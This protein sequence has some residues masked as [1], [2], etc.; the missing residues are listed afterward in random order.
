MA[1]L[2]HKQ[3][4]QDFHDWFSQWNTYACTTN[5]TQ[6]QK[7]HN[8]KYKKHDKHNQ[9]GKVSQTNHH[10]HHH[11]HH[12]IHSNKENSN[13]AIKTIPK[14]NQKV[15]KYEKIQNPF[16]KIIRDKRQSPSN[17]PKPKPKQTQT[18]TQTKNRMQK[19]KQ[20]Q[21]PKPPCKLPKIK[22][23]SSASPP[24][25]TPPLPLPNTFN[26][27][28]HANTSYKTQMQMQ[29]LQPIDPL[30]KQSQSSQRRQQQQRRRRRRRRRDTICEGDYCHVVPSPPPPP[31][32][33][34]SPSKDSSLPQNDSFS[35]SMSSNSN[36]FPIS[37]KVSAICIK[38][39]INK[40]TISVFVSATTF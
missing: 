20:K 32:P 3:V 30:R 18:Q 34:S 5:E 4:T 2:S 12:P 37:Y 31:P 21:T 14:S 6:D 33:S 23:C 40:I 8:C 26:A 19:Q 25:L 28:T 39:F 1:G 13:P 15:V 35:S 16:H 10:H 29:M 17:L 27:V 7:S 22:S 11:H 9:H 38:S 36:M 24:K